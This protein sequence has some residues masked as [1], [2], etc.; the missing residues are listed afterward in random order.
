MIK[1]NLK[2]NRLVKIG[3][4]SIRRYIILPITY[5]SF[6]TTCR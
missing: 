4:N 6:L 5:S 3:I 2:Q 1:I